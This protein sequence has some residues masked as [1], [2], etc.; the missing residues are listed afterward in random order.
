MLCNLD[1]NIKYNINIIKFVLVRFK[2]VLIIAGKLICR[3]GMETEKG[4]STV[5]MISHNVA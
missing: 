1:C 4:Q 5:E 3:A 2:Q